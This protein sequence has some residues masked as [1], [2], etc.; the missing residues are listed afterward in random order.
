M[1]EVHPWGVLVAERSDQEEIMYGPTNRIYQA[2]QAKC[3]C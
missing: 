2:Y 1:E 3:P